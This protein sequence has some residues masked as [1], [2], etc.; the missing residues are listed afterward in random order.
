[1]RTITDVEEEMLYQLPEEYRNFLLDENNRKSAAWRFFYRQKPHTP[2]TINLG[3]DFPHTENFYSGEEITCLP[4]AIPVHQVGPDSYIVIIV[5]GHA[6]GEL[7]HFYS[8]YFYLRDF[9]IRA[10]LRRLIN[11]DTKELL[12]FA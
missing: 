6:Q 3:E 4:G 8:Q 12:S 7:W 2:F 10:F 11:P 5:R 1:M 9:H